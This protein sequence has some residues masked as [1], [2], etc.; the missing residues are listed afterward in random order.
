MSKS[1]NSFLNFISSDELMISAGF[2]GGICWSVFSSKENVEHFLE[3]P[4]THI[5]FKSYNGFLFGI[6]ALFVSRYVPNLI[7]PIIPISIIL[8]IGYH[9]N[10][11]ILSNK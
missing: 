9:Y 2:F 7:K 3:Y 4:L 8:S 10:K 1:H 11:N 6:G 5:F